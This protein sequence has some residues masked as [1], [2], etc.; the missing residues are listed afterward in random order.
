MKITENNLKD[1]IRQQIRESAADDTAAS[2]ETTQGQGQGGRRTPTPK[3][4]RQWL[5]QQMSGPAGQG[6]IRGLGGPGYGTDLS[7]MLA[8]LGKDKG[9]QQLSGWIK[10]FD[11]L[12]ESFTEIRDNLKKQEAELQSAASEMEAGGDEGTQEPTPPSDEEGE[13]DEDD[14]SCT[15]GET[16]TVMG[17]EMVCRNGMWEEPGAD[18]EPEAGGTRPGG[19]PFDVDDNLSENIKTRNVLAWKDFTELIS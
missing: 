15:D 7:D 12:I 4:W 16:R 1:M 14:G 18:D 19:D 6:F 8:A 9:A 5:A 17:R 13:E 11:E 3:K 2:P 10:M